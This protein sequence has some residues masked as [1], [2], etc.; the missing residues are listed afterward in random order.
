MNLS[1]LIGKCWR[2]L[3][4]LSGDD[5]YEQYLAHWRAHHAG[6]DSAPLSRAAF[7]RA[8]MERKWGGVRRCC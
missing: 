4:Q 5:A 2:V 7:Y 1:T 6:E 8:E 3:R